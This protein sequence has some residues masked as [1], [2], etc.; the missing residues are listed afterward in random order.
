[1]KLS[2]VKLLMENVETLII[3]ESF[4][5]EMMISGASESIHKYSS[6]E[7]IKFCDVKSFY[8]EV[9]NPEKLI[10]DN[11]NGSKPATYSIKDRI[12][13]CDD[14]SDVELCFTNGKS[15]VYRLPWK[16]NKTGNNKYQ[17]AVVDDSGVLRISVEKKF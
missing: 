7:L 10:L 6:S 3:P 12:L 2:S 17:Q 13:E 4:V 15:K 8:V 11:F 16:N 14:I 5:G 1:M 9:K